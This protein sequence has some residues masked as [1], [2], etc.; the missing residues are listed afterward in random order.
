LRRCEARVIAA[1]EYKLTVQGELSDELGPSFA[2]M[3]L[4]REGGNT[5]L[6]GPVRDQAELQAMLRR[7]SDLGL[8]LLT[9]EAI[10]A[11]DQR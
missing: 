5:A 1:R 7:I 4:T 6:V 9:V 3:T 8:T 2:G 11:N 10:H